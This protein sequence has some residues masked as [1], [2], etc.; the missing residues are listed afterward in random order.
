MI[1]RKKEEQGDRWVDNYPWDGS[2][3]KTQ[4]IFPYIIF[5]ITLSL[6]A[7]FLPITLSAETLYFPQGNLTLQDSV[8]MAA[9]GDT[10]IV[11][12]GTYQFYYDNLTVINEFLTLK[13]SHGPQQT[14][15]L[16]RG[17]GS[18]VSFARDSKAVLDGF[19]ITS[20]AGRRVMD[21]QGGGI[22]CAPESAPVIINNVIAENEAVF[23]G[24]IYCDT[25]SAPILDN[26][27][28]INNRAAVNGGGVFS[29]RSSA[30]ISNNLFMDNK[31]VNSGGAIG[32]DRDTSRMNNNIIWKNRAGFGGGISCD[33]AASIIANNTIVLNSAD[34]GGGIVVEKGSVRLTNLILWHN[35][36][37]DLYL[38]QVGPSARPAHSLI[39]DGSFRGING[40]ISENP[41][42]VDMEKG[43]FHL[44]PG[45]PAIDTGTIDPFYMDTDGSFND[46]GAYGGPDFSSVKKQLISDKD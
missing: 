28:I 6:V 40:N 31:A 27:D 38:K 35:K 45:S 23:G 14:I 32:S 21:L 12:P 7:A 24:G 3:R 37:D 46:M 19:T 17:K 5:L 22:Y 43:L 29:Y 36:K 34:Y 10:I 8:N 41:T 16:G 33:R 4:M 39:G 42:F 2:L 26:N 30:I 15:L 1:G 18:V 9:P 20:V 13:S 44:L 11:A 25:L